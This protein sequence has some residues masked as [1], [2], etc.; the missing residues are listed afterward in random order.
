MNAVRKPLNPEPDPQTE[1]ALAA[2]M[3]RLKRRCA[4]VE[5]TRAA[6][7]IDRKLMDAGALNPGEM[8]DLGTSEIQKSGGGA[9]SPTLGE[10]VVSTGSGQPSATPAALKWLE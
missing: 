3:E 6:S 7:A 1:A 8:I 10:G 2:S 9:E 5:A 4:E